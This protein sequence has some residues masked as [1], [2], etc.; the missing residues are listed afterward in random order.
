MIDAHF[1]MIHQNLIDDVKEIFE[2]EK[3]K[4]KKEGIELTLQQQMQFEEDERNALIYHPDIQFD[5][6][7]CYPY[8]KKLKK[9]QLHE[10]DLIKNDIARMENRRGIQEIC[11]MERNYTQS[12]FIFDSDDYKIAREIYFG[13]DPKR[14]VEDDEFIGKM[15]GDQGSKPP[16]KKEE[17]DDDYEDSSNDSLE[18]ENR[19][20]RTTSSKKSSKKS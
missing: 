11:R 19:T 9:L 6:P 16:K 8:S 4:R 20:H 12:Y 15:M 18:S 3:K 17:D 1:K 2:K 14:E 10:E 5:N 13:I 7:Q